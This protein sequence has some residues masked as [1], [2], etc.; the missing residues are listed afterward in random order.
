MIIHFWGWF[1]LLTLGA[2]ALCLFGASHAKPRHTERRKGGLTVD[3]ILYRSG[4]TP[5]DAE[6]HKERSRSAFHG[7]H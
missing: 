6:G 4:Q 5:D 3:S 7:W 2:Y 1:A